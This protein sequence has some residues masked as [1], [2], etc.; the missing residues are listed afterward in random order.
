MWLAGFK[1][2][3]P[4]W[5]RDWS[6]PF[7]RGKGVRPF[8]IGGNIVEIG[9]KN[10]RDNEQLIRQSQGIKDLKFKKQEGDFHV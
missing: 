3:I 7:V 8:T 1:D 5:V 6:R 10:I 2:K 9:C 4:C